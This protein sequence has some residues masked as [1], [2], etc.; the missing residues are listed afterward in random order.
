MLSQFASHTFHII[1]IVSVYEYLLAYCCCCDKTKKAAKLGGNVFG[2]LPQKC[3]LVF[4]ISLY[5]YQETT[6]LL[7]GHKTTPRYSR[8]TPAKPVEYII[9]YVCLGTSCLE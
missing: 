3:G 8:N 6:P 4:G 5:P 1:L 2:G 9:C 7:I